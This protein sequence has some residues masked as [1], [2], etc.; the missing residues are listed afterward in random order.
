LTVLFLLKIANLTEPRSMLGEITAKT[1]G[2]LTSVEVISYVEALSRSAWRFE[3]NH[4]V[5]EP[6]AVNATLTVSSVF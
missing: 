4:A 6:S 1:S 3:G 5:S 2:D